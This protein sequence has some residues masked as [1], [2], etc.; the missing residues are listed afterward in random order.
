V[1]VYRHFED[2]KAML[3]ACSGH[4]AMQNP[5]PH[6]SEWQA[7]EDAQARAHAALLAFNKYY[8]RCEEMLSKVYRDA[9]EVEALGPIM[10]GFDDYFNS[11]A[12]KLALDL[13]NGESKNQLKSVARHLVR[14]STWQSL[15]QEN[16]SEEEIAEIGLKWLM[17][18]VG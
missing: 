1:T 4:W 3:L 9:S 11:I 2:E 16:L 5:P 13:A 12:D 7:I 8:S 10:Q 6:E 14:F 18:L 15:S 17:R